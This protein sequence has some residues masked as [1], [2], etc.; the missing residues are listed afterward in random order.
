MRNIRIIVLAILFSIAFNMYAQKHLSFMGVPMGQN[1]NIFTERLIE[2]GLTIYNSGSHLFGDEED[3]DWATFSGPFWNF[4]C[5]DNILVKAPYVD[6]G[7]S[8]VLVMARANRPTFQNLI[9]ALNT[10]YGKYHRLINVR[11]KGEAQY[12]WITSKGNIEVWRSAFAE[13][14]AQCNIEI[15]YKDYLLVN[16]IAKKKRKRSNDL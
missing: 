7:V 6:K 2:R 4:D 10:K 3:E 12:I 9:S 1:I 15:T 5:T 11:F 16:R 13:D 14:D 8:S